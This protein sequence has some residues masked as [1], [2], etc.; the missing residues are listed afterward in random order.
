MTKKALIA[1]SGGV[2][3][4]AAAYLTKQAGYDC[5]GVTLKLYHGEQVGQKTCGSLL[6]IEDAR[7][8]ANRIN[9]PF[10][11]FEC[12]QEFERCV[13]D[14]FVKTYMEGGTPNPCIDCNKYIKFGKLIDNAVE[15]GF[16]C[17][18]TG[19]YARI[20][21]CEETGRWLLKKGLDESKDQSYV[22]YG[23][24]QFQLAHTLLPLGGMSKEDARKIAFENGFENAHKKDSQDICFVPDGDYVSFIKGYT[25][26]SFPDGDFVHLDGRVLGRHKGI[27][28]YTIGQRKGLG[29][30][31]P[32]PAF[33]CGKDVQ[34]NRV[35][36]G[37]NEDLFTTVCEATDINLISVPEI[38][39]EM[40]VKAKVRY[41][42]KEQWATVTQPEPDK[43]RIV[44][45]EPQRAIAKGQAVVL[46]QD[47]IV[48]GGGTLL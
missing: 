15:M 12:K 3:S 19:H 24:T 34:N 20:E 14:R 37:S 26:F 2:D 1:M 33:V 31:L 40:R 13:I 41:R 7:A 28:G 9:M 21:F 48:V 25:G 46:Y 11:V 44:F 45:D 27:I 6:E 42:Q 36:L 22:L 38:K 5:E 47:D 23:L 16:D 8:A 18:V 29:L 4:T 17:I 30:S 43:L 39:G 32:A 35:I 10:H